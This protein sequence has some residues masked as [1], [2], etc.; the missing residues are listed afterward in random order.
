MGESK[1]YTFLLK[2]VENKH[3]ISFQNK[4]LEN[5]QR[6]ALHTSCQAFNM[7]HLAYLRHLFYPLKKYD[8]FKEISFL[9]KCFIEFELQTVYKIFSCSLNPPEYTKN[10]CWGIGNWSMIILIKQF[11][12]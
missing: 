11:G 9:L 5:D 6:N 2:T 1:S 12:D 3:N 4:T 7:K 8:N 10:R